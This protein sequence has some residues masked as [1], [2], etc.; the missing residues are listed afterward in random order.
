MGGG[1]LTEFNVSPSPFG[2]KWAFELFGTYSLLVG[3][4]PRFGDRA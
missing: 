3:M 4:R 1:S 2:I